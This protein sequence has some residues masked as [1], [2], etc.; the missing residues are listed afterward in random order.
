M[1]GAAIVLKYERLAKGKGSRLLDA[2]G[3]FCPE[4]IFRLRMEIEEMKVG[5]ILEM[6]ADDPAAEEDVFR[7]AKRTGNRIIAFDKSGMAL[8]FLIEKTKEVG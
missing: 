4:P 2:L 3:L 6:I 5:E 7:W 1:V 8:R